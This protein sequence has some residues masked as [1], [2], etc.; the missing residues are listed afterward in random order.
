MLNLGVMSWTLRGD[1]CQSICET[2]LSVMCWLPQEGICL[3]AEVRE[4]PCCKLFEVLA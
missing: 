2:W 1:T 4:A 3:V